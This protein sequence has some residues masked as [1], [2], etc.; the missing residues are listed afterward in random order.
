MNLIQQFVLERKCLSFSVLLKT[1]NRLCAQQ[2]RTGTVDFDDILKSVYDVSLEESVVL[3]EQEIHAY[4][5]I[6]YESI[7]IPCFTVNGPKLSL[8]EGLL[9]NE[10]EFL[11]CLSQTMIKQDKIHG[12]Q[13]YTFQEFNKDICNFV[14]L[15]FS[16]Y[17]E[18]TSQIEH[19]RDLRNMH[20]VLNGTYQKSHLQHDNLS[21]TSRNYQTKKSLNKFNNDHSDPNVSKLLAHIRKS[22]MDIIFPQNVH[23][24][25]RISC[26]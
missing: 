18:T 6:I 20:G 26:R 9:G 4:S 14:N 8:K 23:N 1:F 5:G 13:S 22:G 25:V 7:L 24:K 2:V 12:S 11:S 3:I 10:K 21:S 19:Y 17:I 16:G 15:Q